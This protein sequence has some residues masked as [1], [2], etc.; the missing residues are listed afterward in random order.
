M[1]APPAKGEATLLSIILTTFTTVFLAELGDKT[2]LAA[3]LLAAESGRPLLVF[4]GAALALICSSLVGVLLGRWLAALLPPQRLERISG[5]L[6]VGLG[7]WLGAQASVG[8]LN[9]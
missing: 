2:Q 8:L 9:P 5:A 3:L 4:A 7:L 1:E 6:M